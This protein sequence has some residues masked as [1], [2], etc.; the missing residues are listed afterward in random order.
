[1]CD[2]TLA[3]FKDSR[4]GAF[5]ALGLLVLFSLRGAIMTL[6]GQW[7][8]VGWPIWGSALVASSALGRYVMVLAMVLLPPVAGRE[9]LARAVGSTL[10]RWDWAESSVWVSLA[11]AP[12]VILL[13]VQFLVA[14]LMLLAAALGLL[15][16][17]N[18]R[19]GGITGDCLGCLGYIGQVGVLLAAAA[20]KQP[21]TPFF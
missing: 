17:V 13:P 18:R 20:R 1:M 11:T 16:V 5:G 10:S 7:G 6:I 8:L 4:I 12:F 14:V 19:L 15:L 9:S 3:I 21:W 2:Q